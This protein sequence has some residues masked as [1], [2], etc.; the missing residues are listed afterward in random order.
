MKQSVGDNRLARS[1]ETLKEMVEARVD[2]YELFS[3][4]DDGFSVEAQG[5]TVDALKA[6]SSLG[7]GLRTID[8]GK[9][10]FGFTS[11]LDEA[12]LKSMV[13][14]TILG[15]RSTAEDK[16]LSFSTPEAASTGVEL[17]TFDASKE[18]TEAERIECALLIEESA[19]GVDPRVQRVRKA[20]YSESISTNR[21][22][23][24]NGIDVTQ[25]AT[26]CSGS[27]LAVAE[28]S[29]EAQMGWDVG[30]S[31]SRGSIDLE[32]IGEGAAKNALRMLGGRKIE[33]V[34]CPAVIENVVVCEL[35]GSLAG[36]FLADNV[37]KGKSMLNEKLGKKVTSSVLNIHDNALMTGGWASSLYDGEGVPCRDTP[38]LV[39]GVV[40]SFLY[41][42]YW[43]AR[44]GVTS[45]GSSS[46]SVYK[47]L[48][49]IGLSNLYIEGGEKGLDEL[50]GEISKGLLITELLG[51]HTINTVNGDF[52][53][54]AAGLWVENGKLLYPVRGMAISG[55][56]LELFGHAA[57][58]GS[59]LRFIGSIGAP[60]IL[61]NEIEASGA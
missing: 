10:G 42:T 46:R 17:A 7:V 54:G 55:N 29:G 45:T 33:T 21:V 47:S 39:D 23:N 12:A 8:K 22:V 31:H 28:D 53:I 43:A 11:V 49:S 41:D 6:R 14:D 9:L 56:L 48:P 58:C 35:L 60:S 34:K 38:L 44:D 59:D 52:S 16:F 32:G 51:V 13:D 18:T 36:S 26:Y 25:S 3:S 24:S 5:G 20:S 37:H 30:L 50:L 57:V 15:S 1:M 2:A 40:E 61:F 19:L 4:H 27:V